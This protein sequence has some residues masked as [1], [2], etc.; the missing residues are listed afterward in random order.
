ML[1]HGK[2]RFFNSHKLF[3]FLR[4]ESG[5]EIFFHLDGYRS[6]F[7]D[8][9]GKFAFYGHGEIAPTPR[10]GN[11]IYFEREYGR[12][13]PYARVWCFV[14][15]YEQAKKDLALRTRFRAIRVNGK[16]EQVL[17]EGTNLDALRLR[18]PRQVFKGK[19]ILPLRF[20]LE[21]CDHVWRVC[22]D[23]RGAV[24]YINADNWLRAS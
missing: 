13:G 19:E 24:I 5:E 10:Q 23:P 3:G 1:E 4:L 18:F 6:I 16:R 9:G 22:A 20:E 21:C 11:V 17:W 8:D 2:V 15:N 14:W 12:R 7:A